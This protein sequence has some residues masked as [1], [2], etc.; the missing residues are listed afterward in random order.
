[1]GSLLRY[2]LIERRGLYME[3]IGRFK[4]G[5]ERKGRVFVKGEFD[6]VSLDARQILMD[7]LGPSE[8][9]EG[10]GVFWSLHEL[11]SWKGI[12]NIWICINRN[13]Q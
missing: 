7:I 8:W 1:L 11:E 12:T 3:I 13:A 2:I 10:L 5:W 9:K 4:G 6:A